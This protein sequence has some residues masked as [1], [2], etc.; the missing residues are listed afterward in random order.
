MRDLAEVETF[1]DAEL[2]RFS[3]LVRRF[4]AGRCFVRK[5]GQHTDEIWRFL[6][7]RRSVFEAYFEAAGWEFLVREDLGAAVARPTLR[8]HAHLFSVAQTHMVYHL[9]LA[10]HEAAT[11]SDLDRMDVNLTFGDLYEHVQHTIP[12]G[13]KLKRTS[14]HKAL[15]R[16]REF[17]AVELN[18]GFSADAND[19][20]RV[21]PVIEMLIPREL[22]E[23]Q[24]AVA[25]GSQPTTEDTL[26]GGKELNA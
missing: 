15:S 25:R 16:L 17:G 18:R 9:L 21:L 20:I 4:L 3:E 19:T 14:F 24:I 7:R 22:I 26:D 8:R 1:T 12:P 23:R 5:Q 6:L 13:V 2:G 11:A 10:Y